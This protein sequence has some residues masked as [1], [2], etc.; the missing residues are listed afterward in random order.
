MA[1][2]S[3][4]GGGGGSRGSRGGG[5]SSSRSSFG[6]RGMRHSGGYHH[7]HG[8]RRIHRYGFWGPTVYLSTGYSSVY[9]VLGA[10]MMFAIFFLIIAASVCSS[11]FEDANW[12][13]REYDRY[14]AMITTAEAQGKLEDALVTGY[15]YE[16]EGMYYLE[17]EYGNYYQ[18]R[19]VTFATYTATEAAD[20][21]DQTITICY[22]G[23][24]IG[25]YTETIPQEFKNA[26]LHDD[27]NYIEYVSSA[28]TWE[29]VRN[30]T[31]VVV[32][33]CLVAILVISQK[34]KSEPDTVAETTSANLSQDTGATTLG[35]T[36]THEGHT[37][38]AYCGSKLNK[39]DTKCP[40]CGSKIL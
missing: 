13:S 19:D 6:S 18:Y 24:S 32:I 9:S 4:G 31:I 23:S 11:Y 3:R 28:K 16:T 1:R 15:Y 21:V 2:G 35:S 29:I 14:K 26:H 5:F 17:Y 25:M 34:G 33:G 12:L 30:V 37:Y 7:Y 20:R 38:C 27:G 22:T 39:E 36:T 8:P 10:L 40:N